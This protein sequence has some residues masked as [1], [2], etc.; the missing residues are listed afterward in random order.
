MLNLGNKAGTIRISLAALALL[1]GSL[2]VSQISGLA[3][4]SGGGRPSKDA[5]PPATEN[6]KEAAQRAEDES[7]GTK[8]GVPFGTASSNG[9][10]GTVNGEV[11][12]GISAAPD[13]S[14]GRPSGGNIAGDGKGGNAPQ[15]IPD[16]GFL[17]ITGSTGQLDET[18]F[19][20]ADFRNFELGFKNTAP[21]TTGTI[22]ARYNITAVKD[23]LRTVGN[24]TNNYQVRIRFRDDGG[25]STGARVL[26]TLFRAGVNTGSGGGEALLTFDSNILP[27]VPAQVFRTATGT[28]CPR[29]ADKL[30]FGNYV[31]WA[32]V[33]ISRTDPNLNANFGSLQFTETETP[34]TPAP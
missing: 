22:V 4:K 31:Y 34:C 17:T 21:R 12:G 1:A 33:T 27:A 8:N 32:E 18:G 9:N 23:S 5:P 28:I 16:D 24:A 26:V 3:Q 20:L 10:S 29:V 14:V 2:G 6:G 30:D 13:S 19:N 11:S 25:P 15:V 7:R